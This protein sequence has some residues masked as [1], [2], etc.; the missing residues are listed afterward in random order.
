MSN[1]ANT[2]KIYRNRKWNAQL[3]FWEIKIG[4]R[5]EQNGWL[6]FNSLLLEWW[7]RYN[8]WY[9]KPKMI[10]VNCAKTMHFRGGE[11]L[12]GCLWSPC[13]VWFFTNFTCGVKLLPLIFPNIEIVENCRV[14]EALFL[15]GFSSG[16]GNSAC[17]LQLYQPDGN[18]ANPSWFLV[19]SE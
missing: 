4:L 2:S 18:T 3:I 7:V 19:G 12:A 9:T 13:C 6:A 16:L 1:L 14:L 17:N 11:E 8:L 15:S 10:A 5:Q